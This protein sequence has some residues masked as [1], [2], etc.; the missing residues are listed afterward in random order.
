MNKE[1]KDIGNLFKSGLQDFKAD[2]SEEEW[3]ATE[4]KVRGKNFF[5]FSASNFN[6][7]YCALFLTSFALSSIVFVDYFFLREKTGSN[8]VKEEVLAP[9]IKQ[10]VSAPQKNSLPDN[11]SKEN[12]GIGNNST[13][14]EPNPNSAKPLKETNYSIKNNLISSQDSIKK[15]NN[16]IS[17]SPA[18]V[19]DNNISSAINN[20]DS[21][22]IQKPKTK[23]IV[24]ITRQDTVRVY[25]TLDAKKTKKRR[26]K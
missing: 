13:S 20:A 24:Y 7:Y 5:R 16:S 6:I 4:I 1:S 14:K 18:T 22:T 10:E 2:I 12:G 23:K 17:A 25:D 15:V 9:Q 11:N 21:S 3:L 19:Q 26:K 8:T